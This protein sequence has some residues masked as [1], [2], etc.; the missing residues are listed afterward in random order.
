MRNIKLTAKLLTLACLVAALGSCT[1]LEEQLN[2]S[3]SEDFTPANTQG[4]TNVTRSTPD[5]GLE[6]AFARLRNGSANHQNYFS[7][8]EVT[9][10][11]VVITQK[12]GD[13]FDGGIWIDAHQHNWNSTHPALNGMW[14]DAYSAI[15]EANRLIADGAGGAAG[16]AQLRV[17]RAFVVWKLMD[18]FGRVKIPTALG[19]DVPQSSR[20][21]AFNF[22][23]SE[24][25]ASL[26]DLPQGRAEYGRVSNL[27]T[28]A[29]LSRLY[30][31]AEVYT[32][33]ARWQEAIDAADVVINSGEYSLSGDFSDIFSPENIDNPEHIW[34]IPYDEATAGGMNFAQMTLHYPSQLTYNLAEQPW[35]G[36][37]S[38]EAF[39]NSFDDADARKAASFIAGEQFDINGNPI[40]DLAFD[41]DDPDG[42]PIN[43][44]PAINELFPSGSR[45]A[46]VRMGKYSSKLRQR[47]E[48]DNDYVLFRLAEVHLNRAEA[49]SRLAGNWN[50][51]LADVNAVRARAGA[52]AF[53]TMT[54]ADFLAERGREMF[55]ES[56]RRIDLIR[57]DAWGDAWWEK[58]AHNDA[59]KNVFP[60]PND[61]ILASQSEAFPLTQNPGYN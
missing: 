8:Q 9:T 11:E 59:F 10:D 27:S 30:L 32:G 33:T 53:T 22:I 13:W 42:A 60:I 54:A 45:Q 38:L 51:G 52:T 49:Q 43:Y 5:D 28:Q 50:A 24:L 6:G 26:A 39:Y 7:M 34:T 58:P 44:T 21:D 20:V 37:S 15:G 4:A 29:F 31:N 40:L 56:Q 16:V 46:G 36:Y 3:F 41:P 61:Q 55:Q 1:D 19:T 23:E 25:L 12:G 57:F 35:N 17:L 48:M 2:D 18:S 47:A 14:G